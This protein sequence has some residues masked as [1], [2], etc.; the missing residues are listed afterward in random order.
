MADQAI[1]PA[2]PSAAAPI[3]LGAGGAFLGTIVAPVKKA[4][5]D[6]LYLLTMTQDKFDKK[7]GSK[8][9]EK[10]S[11][12]ALGWFNKITESRTAL[13]NAMETAKE[14]AT[15]A[16]KSA[17]EASVEATKAGG[18]LLND[19]LLKDKVFEKF[20]A[21]QMKELLPKAKGWWAVGLG[22]LGLLIGRVISINKAVKKNMALAQ[23][24]NQQV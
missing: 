23:Q 6:P 13:K 17:A 2:R 22:L 7:I 1:T 9:T 24:Q 18:K 14:A 5:R 3:L 21:K 12:E 19:I 16:G 11:K 15:T 4:Y 10:T 8:V 20:S